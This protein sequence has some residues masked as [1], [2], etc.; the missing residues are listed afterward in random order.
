MPETD[1]NASQPAAQ[2]QPWSLD[3]V[4]EDTLISDRDDDVVRR[5]GKVQAILGMA[6][7]GALDPERVMWAGLRLIEQGHAVHTARGSNPSAAI[8]AGLDAI[9]DWS[10]RHGARGVA[11]RDAVTGTRIKAWPLAIVMTGRMR[12]P[13]TEAALM[14]RPEAREAL[15]AGFGGTTLGHVFMGKRDIAGLERAVAGGLTLRT[16]DKACWPWEAWPGEMSDETMQR[17]EAL[18]RGAFPQDLHDYNKAMQRMQFGRGKVTR[19]MAV[20]A[21]KMGAVAQ[22]LG[23]GSRLSGISALLAME[24]A[25]FVSGNN[26][27]PPIATLRSAD[28]HGLMR[29]HGTALVET[30]KFPTGGREETWTV[31]GAVLWASL[32]SGSALMRDESEKALAAGPSTRLALLYPATVAA[33]DALGDEASVLDTPIFQRSGHQA[34]LRGLIALARL[35]DAYWKAERDRSSKPELP[36]G[37]SR[38]AWE[39][40][41]ASTLRDQR[42]AVETFAAAGPRFG[43][44]VRSYMADILARRFL[45]GE[46]GTTGRGGN[47]AAIFCDWDNGE[48]AH[49]LL[50]FDKAAGRGRVPGGDMTAL[51]SGIAQNL[52]AASAADARMFMAGIAG[53][54]GKMAE[55]ML[56]G[57]GQRFA[58]AVAYGIRA[59]ALH[60][61]E[62]SEALLRALPRLGPQLLDGLDGPDSWSMLPGIVA[63]VGRSGGAPW[64]RS[65][66][67]VAGLLV[68]CACALWPKAVLA[69]LDERTSVAHDGISVLGR[70]RAYF[71]SKARGRP[72]SEACAANWMAMAL[73][74]AATADAPIADADWDIG[75]AGL[76]ARLLFLARRHCGRFSFSDLSSNRNPSA[77]F[78]ARLLRNLQRAVDVQHPET[79]AL[80]AGATDLL[81]EADATGAKSVRELLVS[82]WS[83]LEAGRASIAHPLAL[84]Q[85][86]G[87]PLDNPREAALA[88]HS[89]LGGR[90]TTPEIE[91]R[92]KSANQAY[93]LERGTQATRRSRRRA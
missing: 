59:C 21:V 7:A 57:D 64:P 9:L 18:G 49:W 70:E 74:A 69:S 61:P 17:L 83:R 56:G 26:G 15:N 86:T 88:L 34:T 72:A 79:G 81:D 39:R 1:T 53:Q 25:T 54:D 75:E 82:G 41:G 40:R 5:I 58:R 51:L 63:R 91:A 4:V 93:I 14:A 13:R 8:A 60:K 27:E 3:D 31:A 11:P 33:L 44:A 37:Y 2:A 90:N 48:T 71:S 23:G 42:A 78:G 65:A 77:L 29:V 87:F 52:G 10:I 62:V 66:S 32:V 38:L 84:L 67:T 30:A 76:L 28:A 22:R 35:R 24:P 36:A 47:D 68:G 20:R 6:R 73:S 46:P 92:M 80:W 43:A 45:H 55:L 16:D 19:D 85:D 89:M 50:E 12:L